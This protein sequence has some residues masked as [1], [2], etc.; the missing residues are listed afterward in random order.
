[1]GLF[2][3]ITRGRQGQRLA[4]SQSDLA[5]DTIASLLRTL[6]KFAL[7]TP[8]FS[9]ADFA[10]R[11]N[12]LTRRLLLWDGQDDGREPQSPAHR[13]H[14]EIRQLVRDQRRAES[15]TYSAQRESARLAIADV[16]ASLRQLLEHRARDDDEIQIL[17]DDMHRVVESGDI[18]QIRQVSTR[19]STRVRAIL[20]AER[21]RQSDQLEALSAQ[22]DDMRQ[23]LVSAQE[24]TRKDKLTGLH[25]RGALDAHLEEAVYLAHASRDALTLYM[26]DLDGF[27]AIN[28]THGHQ[29]GDQ[30]LIAVST[31]LVRLFLRKSDFV[32]R[33]GGEEFA[34]VCK[35]IGPE[36]AW[37]FGER[38]RE[39]IEQLVIRAGEIQLRTTI[40]VGHATLRPG[41]GAA[42]LMGRADA[43]LYRA[44]RSGRNRVEPPA[45]ADP[46]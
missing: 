42:D 4:D 12:E 2:S 18:G 14:G 44:K 27:K 28:D 33:F 6:A 40:S 32:A 3:G 43:A 1:M 10:D 19:V 46:A 22:L 15:R 35:D 38:A 45:P 21:R 9:V 30:V 20:D 23:R 13:T 37:R 7:P 11:C 34:A 8:E 39:A 36:I 24:E 25:N 29:V 16:V 31:Q 17:L 41:E 5:R 26:L